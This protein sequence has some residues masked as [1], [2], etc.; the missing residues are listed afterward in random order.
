[1]LSVRL[2]IRLLFLYFSPT[3]ASPCL[4]NDNET[5]TRMENMDTNVQTDRPTGGVTTHGHTCGGHVPGVFSLPHLVFFLLLPRTQ[6]NCA[7]FC[8]SFHSCCP[9]AWCDPI[10]C[11]KVFAMVTV[12]IAEWIDAAKKWIL[13]LKDETSKIWRL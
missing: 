10:V 2:I 11:D 12:C 1:M 7:V 13:S 6:T 8:C 4:N 9:S 3:R 5:K